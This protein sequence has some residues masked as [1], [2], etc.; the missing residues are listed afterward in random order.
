MCFTC[1]HFHFS[2]HLFWFSVIIPDPDC[3]SVTLPTV[4]YD[5]E[6]HW[7]QIR[8]ELCEEFRK[9]C[10]CDWWWDHFYQNGIV[11]SGRSQA[12]VPTFLNNIIFWVKGSE[13]KYSQTLPLC[14]VYLFNFL[15]QIS[16]QLF[17]WQQLS[18]FKHLDDQ[19]KLLKSKLS[20]WMGKK[21]EWSHWEHGVEYQVGCIPETADL[22]RD[23]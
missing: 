12:P 6:A 16:N 8:G 18:V 10:K 17:T 22:L 1:V 9:V 2:A 11:H 13:T 14:L 3:S 23:Q 21:G 20:F 4:M 7:A 19:D 5:T 15:M